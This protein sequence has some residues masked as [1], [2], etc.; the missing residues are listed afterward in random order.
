M[1]TSYF[2]TEDGG[3]MKLQLLLILCFLFVVACSPQATD[4]LTITSFEECVAAGN[5]VLESYPRQCVADGQRF[6]ETPKGATPE[7]AEGAYELDDDLTDDNFVEDEEQ[8]PEST[9]DLTTPAPEFTLCGTNRPEMCTLEYAPVCALLTNDVTCVTEPCASTNAVKMSNAC[10]ACAKQEVVGYYSL[11]CDDIRFVVCNETVKTGV[12]TQDIAR[13][14]GWI[15]VDICP[16]NYDMYTTQTGVRMCILS[17]DEVKISRWKA[18]DASTQS[19]NCVKA[20]ETTSGK[21]ID[22]AQYRCVPDQYAERLLFR[23]GQDRLDE[24]G[25]RSVLIA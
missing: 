23:A 1:A 11:P 8:I 24:N 2:I 14:N 3:F 17:Y 13:E 6:V 21:F 12:R 16:G 20:Y 10:G 22:N 25:E 4:G 15:C 18:C 7:G 19:C 9:L 5:P